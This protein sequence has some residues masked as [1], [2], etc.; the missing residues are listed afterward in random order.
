MMRARLATLAGI[1]LVL[2]LV[3]G[4]PQGAWAA[5]PLGARLDALLAHAREHN[6]ELAASALEAEAAHAGVEPAGALPDPRFQL[7][8]MDVTNTMNP[9]RSSS[10]LPGEVGTTRYRVVQALPFWGKRGLR[11]EVAA[12]QAGRSDA[13]RER[14]W[15]EVAYRIKGGFALHYQAFGRS[16][17]LEETLALV[18]LL[19][20]VA[21]ARYSVGLVPQ[22]DVIRAQSER[23][24]LKVDLLEAERSRLDAAARLNAALAREP[25][26]PLAAPA[27]LPAGPAALDLGALV[28]RVR[29]GSPEIGAERA[30]MHA[31]RK[32][33]ELTWLAR[34]PDFAVGI[35][36]NRPA[37]G[38]S[39]WD[40]MLEVNI[41]LQQSARRAQERAAVADE[42]AA[43]AR[44]AAAE[45]RLLG[46]LG[47]AWAGFE[48]SRDK[49][50]LLRDTLLP[51]ADATLDAARAGYATGQV[52]FNTVIEAQRQIL[53]TRL[54][55]LDAQAD[56]ALRLAE[57]ELLAGGD[58]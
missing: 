6:P 28:S 33:R 13:L 25:D 29:H 45:A 31:A 53:R 7:E 2:G 30:G 50:R 32:R 38:D 8:L 37:G 56:A 18:D 46:R 44:V 14:T 10:L 54:A 51:Q 48:S 43:E 20:Q 39:N 17:I 35:T 42:Q 5:E 11:G 26:A 9:G 24:A 55:L 3:L 12:A 36:H 21:T 49:A 16:R 27:A 4:A 1:G 52:N 34:Y 58:L 19:E 23:T 57:L 22:Q 47:E 41:P 15:L 40:V